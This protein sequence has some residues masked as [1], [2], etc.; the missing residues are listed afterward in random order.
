MELKFADCGVAKGKT[1]MTEVKNNHRGFQLEESGTTGRG[2]VR[3]ALT[4]DFSSGHDLTV[5]EFEPVLCSVLKAGSQ[6]KILSVSLHPSQ[7]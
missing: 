1:S 5:P 7:T 2:S 4:L 3:E 6:L